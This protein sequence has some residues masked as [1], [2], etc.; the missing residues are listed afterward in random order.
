MRYKTAAFVPVKLNNQRLPGKNTK[1]FEGGKPLITYI[2]NT[3]TKVKGLD[4]ICVYCSDESVIPFL[5]A[6]VEFLKRSQ[7]LDLSSTPI[8]DV[9]RSFVKDVDANVYL[10]THATAPFLAAETLQTGLD[11]V[12]DGEYDSA[13]T[14]KKLNEFLWIDGQPMYDKTRI[15]RTQDI[16]DIYAETT[17]MYVFKKELITKQG[18]RTGDN[19]LLIPVDF[20]EACDINEPVDFDLAQVLFNKYVKNGDAACVK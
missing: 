15:P 3:L 11:A 20:L 17:G 2:L 16:E 8:L 19:P 18:R 9:I 7:S 5:P 13:L 12:V 10:M 1:A 14:V 6:G 4:K